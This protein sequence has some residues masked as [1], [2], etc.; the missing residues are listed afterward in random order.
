MKAG[1]GL[2]GIGKNNND[3]NSINCF[4]SALDDKSAFL[5]YTLIPV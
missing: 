5:C 3:S 1:Y 4:A 2:M